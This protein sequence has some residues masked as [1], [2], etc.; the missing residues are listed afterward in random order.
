MSVSAVLAQF[1]PSL[2]LLCPESSENV[3]TNGAGAIR[4]FPLAFKVLETRSV[5][6]PAVLTQLLTRARPTQN[7]FQSASE[8]H[9]G[10]GSSPLHPSKPHSNVCAVCL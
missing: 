6:V 4:A 10:V 2:D 9:F 1:L 7:E 3:R 8:S 5:S